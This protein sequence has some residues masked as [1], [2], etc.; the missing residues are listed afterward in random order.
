[1]GILNEYVRNKYPNC[2]SL[3]PLLSNVLIGENKFLIKKIGK[4]SIG[5]DSTFD[6]IHKSNLKTKFY[7]WK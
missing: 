1:M 2:R 4:Q 5:V 7:F 3:D 6:L